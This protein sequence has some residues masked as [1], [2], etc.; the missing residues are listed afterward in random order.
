MEK[1]L[2][3]ETSD[4]SALKPKKKPKYRNKKTTFDGIEFDSQKE[5]LRYFQLEQMRKSGEITSLQRQVRFSLNVRGRRAYTYIAD[6]VYLKNGVRV[7]EDVKSEVTKKLGLY[8]LKKK[9]MKLCLGIE[10]SEV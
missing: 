10:I 5:A 4:V 8:R 2:Q 7:V 1:F 6:Y 9:L 3:A